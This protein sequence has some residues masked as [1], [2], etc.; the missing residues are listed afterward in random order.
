MLCSVLDANITRKIVRLGSRS[1]DERISQYSIETLEMVDGQSRLD[2]T[3]GSR[4]RELKMVQEDIT[5]LMGQVLKLD[6]ESDSAEIM[7][8][9]STFYPEHHEYLA[10]PPAWI[11]TLKVL[12][13]TS[14][15]D[16]GVWRVQGRKG[17][18]R[19]QDTSPYAYWKDCGDVDLVAAVVDGAYAR[20][21]TPQIAPKE[22]K[23]NMLGVEDL[24]D[25]EDD[26][27]TADESQSQDSSRRHKAEESWMAVQYEPPLEIVVEE[28]PTALVTAPPEPLVDE[29]SLDAKIGPEDFEDP[30]GFLAAI[31]CERKPAVPT[32]DRPLEELIDYVVDVW[33]MSRSERHRLHKFWVNQAR[34]ELTQNQTDEFE[35]LHERHA[36]MLRECNEGKEEV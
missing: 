6:I 31:G 32:S 4:R 22:N 3:F 23:F 14:D 1:S 35:R 10:H 2:K 15:D 26:Y 11:S 13:D 20:K 30:E 8:Y 7:K 36:K 27:D 24:D 25:S 16:T 34:I 9:L 17:K 21:I 5:K 19:I 33:A 12:F 18:A 28:E 29:P